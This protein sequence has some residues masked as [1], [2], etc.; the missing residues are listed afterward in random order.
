MDKLKQL[1]NQLNTNDRNLLMCAL[2]QGSTLWVDLPDNRFIGV[3]IK[4]VPILILE[5]QH[6]AWSCGRK[7]S[8][9]TQ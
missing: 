8:H 7:L 6:G 4:N 2:E 1:I 5:Y 9:S 3:N